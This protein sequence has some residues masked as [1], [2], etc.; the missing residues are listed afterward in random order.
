MSAKLSDIV[1]QDPKLTTEVTFRHGHAGVNMLLEIEYAPP[2]LLQKEQATEKAKIARRYTNQNWHVDEG[3]MDQAMMNMY[4]AVYATYI[5]SIYRGVDEKTGKKIPLKVRDMVGYLPFHK[6]RIK[7]RLDEDMDFNKDSQ[8]GKE[9]IF[10]LV[11]CFP[12]LLDFL[13]EKVSDVGLFQ[14]VDIKAEL[15]NSEAGTNTN[16]A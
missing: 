10:W 2:S 9:N 5:H 14:S 13:T 6:D 3:G 16:S 1:D 12:P 8:E 4:A 15:G 11:K 7:D